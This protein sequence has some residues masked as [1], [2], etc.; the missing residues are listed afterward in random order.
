MPFRRRRRR[1]HRHGFLLLV[2]RPC[3]CLDPLGPL[4]RF[5]GRDGGQPPLQL[6]ELHI[7]LVQYPPCHG[8]TLDLP[9]IRRILSL[10]PSSQALGFL[11][12]LPL[13][14]DPLGLLHILHPL[15]AVQLRRI[16]PQIP[17]CVG[18]VV[19]EPYCP[20][21]D[22]LMILFF[23]LPSSSACHLCSPRPTVYLHRDA[24]PP[25]LEGADVFT[26]GNGGVAPSRPAVPILDREGV[27]A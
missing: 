12:S 9:R 3:L 23:F 22:D 16:E 10:L 25:R 2:R 14:F 21:V 1:R 27:L 18:A 6:K 20:E 24:A 15:A 5:L 13:G 11:L 8:S 4:P 19:V 17:R 7:P 26:R